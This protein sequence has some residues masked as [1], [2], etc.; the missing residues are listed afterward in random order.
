MVKVGVNGFGRIR[1]LVTRA[2][3]NSGKVN[4]VS[5]NGPFVDLHYMVFMFQYDSMASSMAVKAENGK[6]SSMERPSSR[7]KIPPTSN[8]VMLVLSLSIIKAVSSPELY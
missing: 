1:S 7:S 4:I 5:I 3:F 8:G 6:L 2:A